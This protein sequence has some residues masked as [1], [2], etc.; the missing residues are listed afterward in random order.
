MSFDTP[1]I[2]NQIL[3]FLGVPS[4]FLTISPSPPPFLTLPSPCLLLWLLLPW[5]PG[6][7]VRSVISVWRRR[8]LLPRRGRGCYGDVSCA[9]ARYYAT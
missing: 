1:N 6:V 9:V 7:S 4:S 2:E 3:P 5:L 8:L